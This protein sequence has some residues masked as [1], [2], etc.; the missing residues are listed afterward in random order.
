M[1]DSD[2]LGGHFY[3]RLPASFHK[4]YSSH[5]RK[6][7]EELQSRE[8]EL[9]RHGV[10]ILRG[11]NVWGI[12]HGEEAAF[13]GNEDAADPDKSTTFTVYFDPPPASFH[14]VEARSLI[15][16]PGVYDRPIPFPGWTLPGVLTPGSVQMLLKKQGIVPGKR[17]IVAGSGPLQMAVAASLAEEGAEVAALIDTC[18]LTDGWHLMPSGLW[19]Q[20]E[21]FREMARYFN[22]LRKHHVP[23]LF[24]QAVF[25]AL[26]THDS[27]LK[28]VVIG[29]VDTDGHPIAG[30]Q[31]E[32][33]ADTLCIAYGFA[34]SIAL[35]L[36]LGCAHDY[37]TRIQAYVPR[38][39]AHMQTNQPGVFVAGD[40]T[41]IGGKP[42]ADLQGQVAGISALEFLGF[43]G[44]ED[45]QIQRAHLRPAVERE[46]R[47]ARMLWHRFHIRP[48][49]FDL[50]NEGTIVC[51]CEG[52]TAG[53]V[54]QSASNG[55]QSLVGAKLR[56]RI[57]MGICQGRYCLANSAVILSQVTG[58]EP[59]DLGM[60]R[61]RPPI[62]PVRVKNIVGER[63][64]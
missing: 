7:V 41:G 2:D 40:V 4:K 22:T 47:F 21:R 57:G 49:I 56:T 33:E 53:Q 14:A 10:E 16:A 64:Q 39:D 61:I 46:Q 63:Y 19:G 13:D 29:K 8:D 32:V 50:S 60:M 25:E 9:A 44:R 48:G 62:F 35:T 38:Y 23:I 55:G 1:D 45:A 37:D 34:P 36:H 31:R 24:H 52:V 26:G 17:I 20:W 58:A 54:R 11:R 30:T 18:G 59:E 42:L 51:R 3:K 28:S 27:G 43:L 5:D 15:L 12:F 6:H